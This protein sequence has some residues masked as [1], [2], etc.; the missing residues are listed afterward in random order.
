MESKLGAPQVNGP[1]QSSQLE[2][3]SNQLMEP[4]ISQSR[5]IAGHPGSPWMPRPG[6]NSAI[7]GVGV[8]SDGLE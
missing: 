2:H 1:R 5:V 3:P 6:P 8:M 7:L 4:P